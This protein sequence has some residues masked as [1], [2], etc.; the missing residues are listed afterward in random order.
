MRALQLTDKDLARSSV[1]TASEAARRYASAL[2]EL[3]SE[4]GEVNTVAADLK[5]FAAAV[6]ENADIQ[7]LLE[8]PAFSR[9]D[10]ASALCAIAGKAGYS[11]M[12]HKFF[13][14]IASNGRAS[15]LPGAISCFDKLHADARGVMRAVARTAI[16]M[17]SDQ[18]EQLETL[19]R[20]AVGSD[21]E[22]ETEVDADLV[23]GLQLVIG[24]T[25]IDASIAAKLE[26]MNTAMK[27][28]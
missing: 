12:T 3:A 19:L 18:R 27:G 4:K 16:D 26:R 1:T 17:T 14:M 6:S 11:A 10:K 15:D 23:G 8:S 7:R 9:E 25:L 22:L 28:A 5:A 13:G 21:V 24:S 20:Q 2:F